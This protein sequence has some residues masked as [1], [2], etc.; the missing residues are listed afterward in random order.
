MS[1]KS[2]PLYGIW[3]AMRR[4]CNNPNVLDYPDYGGRGI[5]VCLEWN[6]FA[7]FIA[8][9]GPRPEGYSLERICT[10]GNYEPD[11]CRW[12]TASEQQLN[13]RYFW[14]NSDNPMYL[15]APHGDR[16]RVR[17]YIKSRKLLASFSTLEE[18]MD[19]RD[20]FLYEREFHRR[21]GF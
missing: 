4:R 21:L 7:Q 20:E 12:A 3:C 9:M 18:A 19:Y 17:L 11:N 15:I 14:R 5:S 1:V 16:W 6:S 8:D 2:H 10:N 13:R